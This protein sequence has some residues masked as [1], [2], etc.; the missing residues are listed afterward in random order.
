[1]IDLFG[2]K[3]KT[4][5]DDP[6]ASLPNATKTVTVRGPKIGDVKTVIIDATGHIRIKEG[7]F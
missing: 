3:K 4:N 2:D 6:K 7:E 5:K 1:M